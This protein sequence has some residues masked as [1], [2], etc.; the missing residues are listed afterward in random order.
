MVICV[1]DN[2]SVWKSEI[3]SLS[4]VLKEAFEDEIAVYNRSTEVAVILIMIVLNIETFL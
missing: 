2:E 4:L 3:E 1:L